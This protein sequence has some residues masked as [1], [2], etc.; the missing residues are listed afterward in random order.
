MVWDSQTLQ[1]ME[2]QSYWPLSDGKNKNVRK[3]DFYVFA[4]NIGISK[5]TAQKM[6]AQ[7]VGKKS[8]LQ[9]MCMESYLPVHLKTSFLDLIE[10]RCAVLM[11]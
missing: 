2:N 9:S 10:K 4:E 5:D 7:V 6:M 11:D 1:W 3:I 8:L